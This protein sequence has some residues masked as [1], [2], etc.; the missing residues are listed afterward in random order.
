[1]PVKGPHWVRVRWLLPDPC[2]LAQLSLGIARTLLC[3]FLRELARLSFESVLGRLARLLFHQ[4]GPLSG[5]RNL[6][7]LAPL[8]HQRA[9]LSLLRSDGLLAIFL[10][11]HGPLANMQGM[12]ALL[13]FLLPQGLL[14]DLLCH[15]LN[16]C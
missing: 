7:R 14:P 11:I 15:T 2:Y 8:V 5:L 16:G 4:G 12:V 1:M 13:S 9:R 3:P 6:S 10:R